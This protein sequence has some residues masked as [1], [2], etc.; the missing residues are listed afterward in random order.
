MKQKNSAMFG[1]MENLVSVVV[2]LADLENSSHSTLPFPLWLHPSSASPSLPQLLLLTPSTSF[3][4]LVSPPAPFLLDR[5]LL[6]LPF[7]P[8]FRLL[9][10][11]ET[12][13]VLF[14]KQVVQACHHGKTFVS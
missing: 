8:P 14:L 3:L 2:T 5:L 12:I 6:L 1:E 11:V 10:R 4:A 7:S 9:L 13:F